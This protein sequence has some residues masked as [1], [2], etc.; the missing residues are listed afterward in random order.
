MNVTQPIE[1]VYKHDVTDVNDCMLLNSQVLSCPLKYR[2][3]SI[4]TNLFR[5]VDLP[6]PISPNTIIVYCFYFSRSEE[7]RALSQINELSSFL[8]IFSYSRANSK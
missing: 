2:F 5:V 1:P 7:G 3:A 6:D 4:F 8:I